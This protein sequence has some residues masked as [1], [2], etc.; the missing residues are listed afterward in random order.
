[1]TDVSAGPDSTAGPDGAERDLL[2][3]AT[4]ARTRAAVR[5]L[6]RPDRKLAA[7]GFGTLMAATAVGL[8]TQ[9]LLGHIVDVV[10]EHRSPDALTWPVLALAGVAV[11]QGLTTALG[12]TLVSR[13]GETALARLRELF[14]ERALSLPLERLERAGSGDLNARVTRDV[15]RVADAVRTALPELAR[16]ALSIVLTLAALALLDWRFLLAAL[17]AVPV[18]AHTARWYV[19][20]AVPLYAKERIATGSQQQQLLDTIG[21]ARTVRAYRLQDD[22]TRRVT[23]RSRAAVELTMRGVRLVLRF[24]SRLHIAE[25]VG[26]AA[27]LVTGFLLVRSGSASVGTATAAALYFHSLFGPVNTALVLLDDAQSATAGLA[28][29]VGVVDEPA[30]AADE[31]TDGRT[32]G[33]AGD[34]AVTLTGVSHAYLPGRPVLHGVDLEVRPKERV[35]LVGTTG[36]GKTTLARLVAG[37]HRPEAGR[38]DVGGAEPDGSGRLVGLVTQ[39]VHVFAGPLADDLRLARPDAGDEELRDALATVG[40]L[41]WA[42]A[43]P[44]ALDTVVGDGGHRLTADQAQQLALARLLL[45]DPPVVVLDEATAEAGSSGARLL[46]EAAEQALRGRTALVVAHRL[47]QAAAADRVV[48][49]SDGRV[50]EEGTHG[51]LLAARGR[52]AALW[53]AWSD[54]RSPDE[55]ATADA[56]R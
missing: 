45:A 41:G 55:P 8:L 27:V 20:N 33:V 25:Y 51:E 36:A 38:V 49:L 4:P 29:L 44:E 15:S 6:L 47:S 53:Q 56:P 18:Q 9:P 31:R 40:A 52:Y 5:E 28:R 1:M 35:A 13:L 19:R 23:E 54:H 24:Y 14:V 16:S 17:L 46:D 3:T 12:M 11:V 39:E 22:H 42:E 48:V 32:A 7:A 26:L 34:P 30:P 21:G 43:L 10:T 50:V 2:P 37:L